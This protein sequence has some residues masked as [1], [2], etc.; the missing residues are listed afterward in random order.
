MSSIDPTTGGSNHQIQL[1]DV[2]FSQLTKLIEER[3]GI[4]FPEEKR[5]EFQMRLADMACDGDRFGSPGEFLQSIKKSDELMQKLVDSITIG[6]SYFFRNRP[7][8]DAL[9]QRIFPSLIKEARHRQSLNIWCAGCARGEEPYSISILLREQ[10]PE[11]KGWNVSV[12]A[13]DINTDFLRRAQ[14]GI[15]TKWSFRG[16]DEDIIWKYFSKEGDNRFRLHSDIKRT[17]KFK[18]FNLAKFPFSEGLR[19]QKFDLIICRNVLIYFSFNLANKVVDAF[20]EMIRPGSYLL[21]GHSEAFPSLSK[22]DVIYSNATYYYRYNSKPGE[23]ADRFSIT[24]GPSLSI[25]GIGVKTV[26]PASNQK[27]AKFGLTGQHMPVSEEPSRKPRQIEKIKHPIKETGGLDI[28][29]LL[30]EAREQ[31]N[32]GNIKETYEMLTVLSNGRGKLDNR[33]Y[34]FRAIVADQYGK[35]KEAVKSLKQSIFL[36]KNFVIG[37]FY[38]GVIHHRDG[39]YK[40][41]LRSF[42]NTRNLLKNLDYDFELEGAEGMNAGR[43]KEIVDARFE[44]V[45]LES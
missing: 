25:P 13:T 24:P 32:E 28:D 34:F 8:F 35:T 40:A 22:L 11:V 12:V 36:D 16:V 31:V 23:L 19:N 15:Y 14:E 21:V 27:I 2:Q 44:E 1:S 3:I 26:V 4:C 42:R 41:A 7:H 43:L 9:T 45:E 6:E 29:T 39:Q 18:P 30:Q 33:V 10:F 38:L 5:R 37:H 17:V 20:G